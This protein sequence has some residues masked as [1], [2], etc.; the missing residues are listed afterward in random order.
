MSV[1]DGGLPLVG[2]NGPGVGT[3]GARF[4]A[5]R[6]R[7]RHDDGAGEAQ[8]ASRNEAQVPVERSSGQATGI[9]AAAAEVAAQQA[10]LVTARRRNREGENVEHQT[11][12]F[13]RPFVRSGGRTRAEIELPLEALVSVSATVDVAGGMHMHDHRMV[14]DLCEQPRSIMEVAALAGIPL[15]V[16]RVLV[17]DLAASGDL[18]VHRTVDRVGPQAD[19][20]ERVLT[21]LHEL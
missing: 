9:R 11:S 16:A 18:T 17:G 19:L 7:R 6:T 12:S 15:G 8:G 1:A 21:G 10:A 14:L 20:L 2:M 13:V 4:G 3:T 5:G